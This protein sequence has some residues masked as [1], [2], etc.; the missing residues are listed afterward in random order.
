MQNLRMWRRVQSPGNMHGAEV[1]Q[2]F[3]YTSKKLEG[4]CKHSCTAA[5]R[6]LTQW[7]LS[8]VPKWN[9]NTS[10]LLQCNNSGFKQRGPLLA[11]TLSRAIIEIQWYIIDDG[12]GPWWSLVLGRGT[13]GTITSKI[14]LSSHWLR[15]SSSVLFWLTFA[16][17][18]LGQRRT[19]L[20]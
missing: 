8:T 10:M 14:L 7:S 20:R 5:T 17:N 3:H 1:I 4:L 9:I 18:F 13:I 16:S 6:L 2:R 19:F 11:I 15:I 12:L